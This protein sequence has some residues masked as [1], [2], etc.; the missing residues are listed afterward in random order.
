MKILDRY[1]AATILKFSA[2]ALAGVF[3]IDSLFF[4]LEQLGE[5]GRNGYT[6]TDALTYMALTSPRRIYVVL[7]MAVLLGAMMGLGGLSNGRELTA[8]RAAGVS[9][10]RITWSVVKVGLLLM[11][12]TLFL[13]E[14]LV[15]ISE[16]EAQSQ[17]A[18]GEVE[19]LA[20]NTRY[21]LW[22][23]EGDL[24]INVAHILPNATLQDVTIYQLDESFSL[25]RAVHAEEVVYQGGKWQLKDVVSTRFGEYQLKASHVDTL[26]MKSLLKPDLLDILVV[27]PESLSIWGLFKYTRYLNDNN[28]NAARYELAFWNKV[29]APL[30]NIVMLLVTIPLVFANLRVVSISQRVVQGIMIGLAFFMLNKGLGYA[31]LVMGFPS[32]F[33]ASAPALLFGGGALLWLRKQQ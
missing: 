23:R 9:I 16:H 27:R 26:D 31:G 28:Q 25:Q 4:F 11:V 8:M 29:L 10:G 13:G 24:F 1:I 32:L 17:K 2:F 20:L 12:F 5:V 19:N 30:V 33:S 22:L 18:R 3:A 14:V 7:P 15:P 6:L 21:G